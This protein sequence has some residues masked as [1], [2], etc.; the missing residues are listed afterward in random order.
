MIRQLALVLLII[1]CS[2]ILVKSQPATLYSLNP[3]Q[4]G[5][6]NYWNFTQYSL[7]SQSVINET[8]LN[9]TT[10]SLI[11]I[12]DYNPSTNSLLV[13]LLNDKNINNVLAWLNVQ[14]YQLTKVSACELEDNSLILTQP[15]GFDDNTQKLYTVVS[16]LQNNSLVL[17]EWDFS[18]VVGQQNAYTFEYEYA[19]GTYPNG[20]YNEKIAYYYIHY[21]DAETQSHNIFTFDVEFKNYS[22]TP[23]SL[24]NDDITNSVYLVHT[25]S[26]FNGRLYA[27]SQSGDQLVL[28]S[29]EVFSGITKPVLSLDNQYQVNGI[30]YST[31]HTQNYVT[32]FTSSVQG[33]TTYTVVNLITL[34][35][36]SFTQQTNDILTSWWLITN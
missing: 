36:K 32:L 5:N 27:I 21:I 16:N 30:P 14:T 15:L 19:N 6:R 9:F 22:S 29:I 1:N 20:C 31:D 33:Q 26:Y 28:Y 18:S 23:L 25:G 17:M 4:D 13:M 34:S 10:L 24:D 8:R 35:Y 7:T 12:V 11:G 2:A 3:G